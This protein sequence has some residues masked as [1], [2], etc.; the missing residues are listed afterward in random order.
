MTNHE[1]VMAIM[2]T[3]PEKEWTASEIAHI[4][5]PHPLNTTIRTRVYSV[6]HKAEQY[7]FVKM[8][9]SSPGRCTYWKLIG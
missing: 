2:M 6:L 4:L 9:S 5:E 1:K 3:D 7:G 8:V